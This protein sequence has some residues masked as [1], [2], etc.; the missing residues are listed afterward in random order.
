M[1]LRAPAYKN[2]H[3]ITT[4]SG[5]RGR[6]SLF[7]YKLISRGFTKLCERA[8]TRLCSFLARISLGK[9]NL[10]GRCAPEGPANLLVSSNSFVARSMDGSSMIYCTIERA[11]AT[12][13]SPELS[14][15]FRRTTGIWPM[16]P[17]IVQAGLGRWLCFGHRQIF[18]R[19]G[20]PEFLQRVL[21]NEV[22]RLSPKPSLPALGEP[23]EGGEFLLGTIRDHRVY[24]PLAMWQR[25]IVSSERT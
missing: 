1:H 13:G 14:L 10:G 11:F 2:A 15:K 18:S 19:K 3:R 22:L 20:Q 25:P 17:P 8:R 7:I 23:R 4:N 21:P 6:P 9:E 24:V 16:G 12:V 5:Q